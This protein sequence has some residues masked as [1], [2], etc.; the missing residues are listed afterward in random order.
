M[1]AK[2]RQ[3]TGDPSCRLYDL[4]WS[5]HTD[6][7]MGI[8]DG[9]RDG[10]II[11]AGDCGNP[12][13]PN[14]GQGMNVGIL[15]AFNLGWK[16]AAVVNGSSDELIDTYAAERL[17]L[18]MSLEKFQWNSLKYTTLKTPAWLRW[19]MPG[20]LELALNYGGE[21]ALGRVFSQL[22]EGT[23]ASAMTLSSG[24]E[25]VARRRPGAGCRRCHRRAA[26]PAVRGR[27]YWPVVR[28]GVQRHG[29]QR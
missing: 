13:L 12:I 28:A 6:L 8:A 2:L 29:P 7:S 22:G 14:G 11:L 17:S 20:I 15:D 16:L 27:L 21:A 4:D 25:G 1:E 3:V 18:R 24:Q 10:R 5:T 23:R 26:G 9:L 19:A